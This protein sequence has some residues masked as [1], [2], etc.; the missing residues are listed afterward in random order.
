MVAAESEDAGGWTPDSATH[1]G[2]VA[3]L[4]S[5]RMLGSRTSP[6]QLTVLPT[7]MQTSL[8]KMEKP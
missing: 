7:G 5:M 8:L 4:M 2:L 1:L 6:S 3:K